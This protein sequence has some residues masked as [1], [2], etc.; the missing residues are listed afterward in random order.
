M[1]DRNFPADLGFQVQQ[2]ILV[3]VTGDDRVELLD[4]CLAALGSRFQNSLNFIVLSM[5][6]C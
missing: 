4:R 6:I 2:R 1:V 5:T 3:W